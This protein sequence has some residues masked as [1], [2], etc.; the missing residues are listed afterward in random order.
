VWPRIKQSIEQTESRSFCLSVLRRD[1]LWSRVSN[2][3][4]LAVL[5]DCDLFLV[6]AAAES[7]SRVKSLTGEAVGEAALRLAHDSEAVVRL[8]A[9]QMPRVADEVT[10]LALLV[11]GVRDG[12]VRVAERALLNCMP[13]PAVSRHL[14]ANLLLP[15]ICPHL[16]AEMTD[17]RL[18]ALDA[19]TAVLDAIADDKPALTLTGQ[20]SEPV[21]LRVPPFVRRKLFARNGLQPIEDAA[22]VPKLNLAIG[23]PKA[24]AAEATPPVTPPITPPVVPV[25]PAIALAVSPKLDSSNDMRKLGSSN[26][27]RKQGERSATKVPLPQERSPR[28]VLPKVSPSSEERK[29]PMPEKKKSPQHDKKSPR[30]REPKSPRERERSRPVSP[31]KEEPPSGERRER[32]T[33]TPPVASG[34]SG[35]ASGIAAAIAA[36]TLRGRAQTEAPASP[37]NSRLRM[38][39][40]PKKKGAEEE[41]EASDEE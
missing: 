13:V 41:E 23:L 29:S 15:A 3:Y 9:Q 27:L 31:R 39:P 7:L 34:A 19:A 40:R 22:V 24:A 33:S 1:A 25:V 17:H 2:D 35:I 28:L 30:D 32:A 38:S 8:S 4:A 26:D 36:G 16:S 37:P 11:I 14:L 18:A 21:D 6:N 5:C 20:R 10:C 12:D